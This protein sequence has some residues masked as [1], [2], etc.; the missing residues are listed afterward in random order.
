MVANKITNFLFCFV[1]IVMLSCNGQS[2]IQS[3]FDNNIK[4]KPQSKIVYLFF[5]GEKTN[6]G[7]EII[8]LVD[9]KVSEGFFK[10]EEFATAKDITNTFYKMIL[11]DKNNK[12]YKT[13]IIDNPFSPI[14]ESYGKDS[15]EKQI[16]K[17]SKTE[18][19]Y[20]YNDSGNISKLEIHKSENDILTLILTLKL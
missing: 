1:S 10:N 18:F 3:S 9:K 2:K 6:D 7:K 15:M 16:G 11:F 14:F 5:E 8:K 4:D 19:F 20:R 13:S 12:V 17:L